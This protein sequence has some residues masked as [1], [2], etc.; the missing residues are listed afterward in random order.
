MHKT[1][2]MSIGY[3]VWRNM[4]YSHREIKAVN[5]TLNHKVLCVNM[6]ILPIN[7]LET[8]SDKYPIRSILSQHYSQ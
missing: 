3:V 4:K 2:D 5:D 1:H 6:I 8:V 7:T